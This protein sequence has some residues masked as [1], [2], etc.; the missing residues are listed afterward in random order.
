MDFIFEWWKQYFMM[1]KILCSPQ[2]DKIYIFKLLAQCIMDG[3]RE[4][5]FNGLD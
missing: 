4:Y 3:S 5:S 2:E 1:S